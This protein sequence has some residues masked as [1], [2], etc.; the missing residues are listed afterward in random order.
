MARIMSATSMLDLQPSNSREECGRSHRRSAGCNRDSSKFE[1]L[2]IATTGHHVG[3]RFSAF[4]TGGLGRPTS[5]AGSGLV[6][7]GPDDFN[8]VNIVARQLQRRR[9]VVICARGSRIFRSSP[10]ANH[11]VHVNLR[12]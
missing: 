8:Q 9:F 2:G 10:E 7:K 1:A 3:Y 12:R 5:I 6:V 4:I 11:G